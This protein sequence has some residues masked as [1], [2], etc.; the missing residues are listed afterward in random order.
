M[1]EILEQGVVGIVTGILTTALLYAAKIFL[2]AKVTPF[3]K[4]I[5]Y[6]GVQIDGVWTGT[7]EVTSEQVAAGELGPPFRS[8]SSLFLEQN[9]HDLNGTFHFKFKSDVK[10]FTLEFIV[11]GYMWEGYVTLN[12]TPKDRRVTSYATG[13]LKLHDGGTTLIGTWLFRDVVKE[14]VSQT[15]LILAR[16]VK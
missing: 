5:Q 7:S 13:L 10:D 12:F 4:R 9:A 15:P 11:T 1:S 8:E 3:L 16:S 2:S 14:I 6:Q